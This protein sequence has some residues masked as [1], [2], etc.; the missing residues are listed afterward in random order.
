MTYSTAA[1]YNI[2]QNQPVGKSAPD[3]QKKAHTA[4][5]NHTPTGRRVVF[6]CIRTIIQ[7][8]LHSHEINTR[9]L[10]CIFPELNSVER[11]LTRHGHVDAHTIIGARRQIDKMLP[12]RIKPMRDA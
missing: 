4:H 9:R 2:S 12:K 7:N 3:F 6:R 10:V 1:N 5:A 8:G 11:Q